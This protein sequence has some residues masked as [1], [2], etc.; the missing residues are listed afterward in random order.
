MATIIS[1][2][3]EET[4]VIGEAWATEAQTGW[5]I[6][7]DGDLGAGKTQLV[8]GVA[9]GLGIAGPV[10]SP[11]FTLVCEYEGTTKLNHLDFYRLQNIDQIIAAGLEPYLSPNGITIIEWFSRWT[12]PRPEKFRHAT[13]IQTGENE[14]RIEY[15]DSGT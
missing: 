3:P 7:L 9:R 1:N 6:G 2:S 13:L 11:T 5:V 4:L 14:R 8:K 12:G 10:N 15:E